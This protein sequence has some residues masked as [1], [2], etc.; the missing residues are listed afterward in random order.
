VRPHGARPSRARFP[1]REAY[2][3]RTP[4]LRARSMGLPPRSWGDSLMTSVSTPPLRFLHDFSMPRFSLPSDC[5][6]PHGSGP[7]R[8]RPG[9]RLWSRTSGSAA[10][11]LGISL[12]GGGPCAAVRSHLRGPCGALVVVGGSGQMYCFFTIRGVFSPLSMSRTWLVHD[13]RTATACSKPESDAWPQ[14]LA[15]APGSVGR[16]ARV[17]GR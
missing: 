7:S 13:R 17:P 9:R 14:P 15:G 8:P 2:S 3:V 5:F 1:S 12:V 6:R 4:G 11:C 16:G 10:P